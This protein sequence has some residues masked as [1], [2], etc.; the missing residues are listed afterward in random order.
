MLSACSGDEDRLGPMTGTRAGSGGRALNTGGAAGISGGPCVESISCRGNTEVTRTCIGDKASDSERDC[1]ALSQ[2]CQ[3]NLGCGVCRPGAGR[4]QGDGAEKCNAQGT[5]YEP[6]A[7]CDSAAGE[8]CVES[9]AAC[10]NLCQQAQA[11]NSYIGCEYWPAALLNSQVEPEFEF[12]AVV[13]NPQRVTAQ[14]RVTLG[15]RQVATVEVPPSELRAIKLPWLDALKGTSQVERSALLSPGAYRLTSNVPVT[16]YQFNPLEYRL[17]RDCE[18]ERDPNAPADPNPGECFSYSNDASLLLPTHV[19]TGD[20]IVVSRA[21]MLQRI[22]FP[23]GPLGSSQVAIKSPGFF[24]VIGAEAGN[25]DVEITVKSHVEASLDGAVMELAPGERATFSVAQG[26]VLQIVAKAPM[27]C[28]PGPSDTM[29]NAAGDVIEIRTYCRVGA[30]YDLTGSEV[31]ASGKVA[32]ISG[33]NCGF[34]PY[35]R[36]ACDHHEEAL[37][38]LQAWG[39]DYTVAITEPLRQEPNVIRVVS[40]ADGNRIHIEP[41]IQTEPPMTMND[42]SLNRGDFVEFETHDDFRITGSEALLVAQFLVG[43]DYEGIGTAGDMGLGDPSLSLAVPTEQFRRQYSVLAPETFPLNYLN[44]VAHENAQVE[45]DGDTVTGFRPI[46]G[47]GMVTAR[48]KIDPGPHELVSS[49]FFGVVSYGFGTYTSY[50]VPAGL[51]LAPINI[52][53]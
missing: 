40:G 31:H 49:D 44:V 10:V 46:R 45:L 42:V 34:V 27:T 15:T 14:V 30:D 52:V 41:S 48:V 36:W 29:V 24:A 13:A 47:T 19:L 33:H 8:V 5:A 23:G 3:P 38:P 12:A 9:T 51:D 11:S 6:V 50:M 2:S 32:V 1:S 7:T 21:T 18:G 17:D 53:D 4:C 22:E 20:Y 37:F 39:K 16:V 43:Q 28:T 35:Q 25:T 26:A